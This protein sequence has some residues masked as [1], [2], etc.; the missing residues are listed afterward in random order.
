TAPITVAGIGDMSGD[1]FGN[2]LLLSR[3]L[4]LVAAFDHRHIFLDP[5]PD[6]EAGYGERHRLFAL[7]G[8]SWDDYDRAMIS[9]GGGVFARA[10]KAI[11]L[12]DEARD[13]LDT[14]AQ[15]VT[16]AELVTIVL[17]AP[18]DL[19]WNGGIGTYVKASTET[20][21]EVGDRAN[22]SVR[23]NGADLRCRVVAEG[24]NLG[25]T[26]RGRVEY[27]LNGGYVNTDAID[28][29]AG[30][31]CSDHEVNIKIL[32]DAAVAA[33]EMDVDERNHLLV[34]MTDDV[35]ELVLED[36]R[37]QT[38]ALAMARMQ[39][40]AMV[41]VHARYLRAL[42]AEGLI[43]RQLEFLPT[44][45]QMADRQASGIGLTGPEFA[46]LL[47]YTKTT[48]VDEVLASSLPDDP[49]IQDELAAYFPH[50]ARE[51]LTGRLAD[52]RLHREI[53]AT[54]V[55]NTMVNRAG[56]S[57]DHRMLEET[58]STVPDVTRAYLVARRILRLDEQWDEIET[59]EATI[60]GSVQ[61]ELFL[62]LRQ[63]IER[64]VLW[65]LRSRRPP[66]AIGSTVDAFRDPLTAL[67]ASLGAAMGA[68]HDEARRVVYERYVGAGVPDGLAQRAT[69]WAYQ[70][71]SFDVVELSV[72]R[73]RTPF[74]VATVYWG[75][76]HRLGL[77]WLWDRVGQLPRNDRWQT[78]ARAALRDD[79]L[80]E[81][82]HL[83]D[84][85]LRAGDVFTSPTELIQ[86]WMTANQR[87]VERIERIFSDI[88]NSGV[89]DLTTLSVALRQLRNVV[90]ASGPTA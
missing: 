46:V 76:F 20:H 74:D 16:P 62:R 54:R 52:H 6:P 64:G 11:T 2:G 66:L 28:N 61:M 71:T 17:R 44:D 57:F 87:S 77:E 10:A 55:V 90:M 70:H 23:V 86:T 36:N 7:A 63:F 14:T 79:L 73:G 78:Y 48:N 4:R 21:A 72:A 12:S 65:V 53:V 89:F 38:A 83:T 37:A 59:L 56:T 9:P 47:A 29:S 84:D 22:D 5:D 85:A 75:L 81:M 45:K 42:E 58:G 27:A 67:E 39:A 33:G 51:R 24:G 80:S 41:N 88:A 19:L 32:L 69:A 43:S 50:A 60:A 26:Q 35:A 34:A 8:S 31:D 3:H 15:V 18:V 49:D 13:R 82:R 1:V 40:S 25:L 30:V 68:A